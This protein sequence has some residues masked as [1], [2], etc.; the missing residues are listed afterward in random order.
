MEAKHSLNRQMKEHQGKTLSFILWQRKAEHYQCEWQKT[1]VLPVSQ[2]LIGEQRIDYKRKRGR[3]SS[4]NM[5][6]SALYF[7]RKDVYL[8]CTWYKWL[9]CQ[10]IWDNPQGLLQERGSTWLTPQ[11]LFRYL[12]PGHSYMEMIME[13]QKHYIRRKQQEEKSSK[14]KGKIFCVNFKETGG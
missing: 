10:R 3:K 13:E 2:I 5:A 14:R 7:Y 6:L 12:L 4:L 1:L 9:T 11:K 8:I